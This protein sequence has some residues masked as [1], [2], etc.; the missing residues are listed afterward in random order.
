MVPTAPICKRANLPLRVLLIDDDADSPSLRAEL[1][2]LG[3]EVLGTAHPAIDA[4]ARV[5]EFAPDVIVMR[6]AAVREALV[7]VAGLRAELDAARDKLAARKRIEKAKGILMR[8]RGLD[9]HAAFRELRKLAMDRGI[10]LAE[11][12][13]RV[14]EAGALLA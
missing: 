1:A 9:E 5:P 4:L 11:I 7:H 6:S 3:C 10:K 8:A 13:E 14:I 12:A 2:R